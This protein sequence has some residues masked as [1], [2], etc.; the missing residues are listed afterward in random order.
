MFDYD[1]EI[2]TLPEDIPGYFPQEESERLA[3]CDYY[4]NKLH[5]EKCEKEDQ[6]NGKRSAKNDCDFQKMAVALS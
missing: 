5:A 3:E 4:D 1:R 6:K 2:T